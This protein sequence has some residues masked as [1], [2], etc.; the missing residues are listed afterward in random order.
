MVVKRTRDR[1]GA[2]SSIIVLIYDFT[3]ALG[4]V[5]ANFRQFRLCFLCYRYRCGRCSVLKKKKKTKKKGKEKDKER[6]M[7][8]RRVQ[9]WRA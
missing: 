7:Y 6:K 4:G 3:S 1:N 9:C 8:R 2:L 5:C